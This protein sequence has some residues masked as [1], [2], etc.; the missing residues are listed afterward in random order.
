MRMMRMMNMDFGVL[1]ETKLTNGI[2]TKKAEGYEI[3][4]TNAVS[5]H[6][7][8]V[9]LFYRRS[10]QWHIE[11]TKTFGPNVI[12]T[13]LVSG[14][15]RWIIIGAYVPP[16]ETDGA[17]LDLIQQA[18]TLT[19]VHPLIMLGDFNVEL[20]P[21]RGQTYNQRHEETSALFASLGLQD[22][23][24]NFVQRR[25]WKDW[26]WSQHRNQDRIRSVC[27]YI[28]VENRK[29]FQSFQIKQPRFDSDHRLLKAQLMLQSIQNHRRYVQKREVFPLVISPEQQNKA[30][31]L[32]AE[33]T[34]A[35]ARPKKQD[36]NRVGSWISEKSWRL[37]D[38]RLEAK[39]HWHTERATELGKELRKSL[40]KDRQSR[41]DQAALSIETYLQ[42]RDNR[43]AYGVL[44]GWYKQSTGHVPKPT[45]RDEK[46]T[47][48]EFET[49]FT[50]REPPGDPI[51]IHIDPRPTINDDPPSEEEI[52][53]AI[54]GMGLNKAPGASGIRVEHLRQW[55]KGATQ[56]KNPTFVEEWEKILRLVEMAFTGEN[57]P[58]AFC[59]GILVLIPKDVPDEYRGI[60]L[61]EVLYKL[62]SSIINRRMANKIP[63]HDSIHGFR[64]KR[65]TGTAIIEAKLHMQLTQRAKKPLFMIFL[66]LKKAYDTLNRQRTMQILEGYGVGVNIRRFIETIW[67]GDTMIP[68]QAG[69][70]G[71]PFRARRGVRQGDIMSPIIFNIVADAVIREWE[72]LVEE[73]EN[74]DSIIGSLFYADDGVLSGNDA[75]DIQKAMNILT[76]VFSRVGLQMN[77]TKTKAMV[78]TGGKVNAPISDRAY[79]RKITGIGNTSREIRLQKIECKLCGARISNAGLSKHQSS[80]KCQLAAKSY[81]THLADDLARPTPPQEQPTMRNY[82]PRE[83]SFS[84]VKGCMTGCPLEGCPATFKTPDLM[85]KH[86]RRRHPLDTVIIEEEGPLPKCPQCGLFQRYVGTLHQN[87]K[88]C[89]QFAIIQANRI[90]GEEQKT[91]KQTIFTI[92]S[93]P[94]ETVQEFKYLGR[95]LDDRDQDLPAVT[96]N[97]QRAR[98]RWGMIGRILKK[99]GANPKAMASFYKAI[100]QSIL[101]YGSESWVLTK[102]ML[103][104]LNNFHHRCARFITGRHIRVD[105]N[106]YWTYPS[107]GVTLSQAG[108]FTME[109]Y[110][111]RRKSTIMRYVKDRPIYTQCTASSP[112]AYN[113]RQLVWWG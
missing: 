83:F 58:A 17:T 111:K 84:L 104:S 10:K 14:S 66:D 38:E 64:A 101:L 87:T 39:R 21:M 65:G 41:I 76:N 105:V 2:H 56:P 48:L 95:I 62:I 63:F 31:Q 59:N 40:R 53:M 19:N 92:G 35:V 15:K 22:L 97:L 5:K 107:T 110:I 23:G 24:R 67:E 4:A 91:A 89:Q 61:L 7:G 34:A 96:Y 52:M 80:R 108:L 78:M 47:R 79:S 81:A 11:G 37:M 68:K 69:F 12:R 113:P 72:V 20:Q 93:T 75:L 16:S 1:T 103:D 55:M 25:G 73:D 29:D 57:I 26:T 82:V 28:L 33:L 99:K 44:Q 13:E 30:D 9:A 42:A 3:I 46:R 90:L 60:A 86:F 51:R 54:R 45:F 50:E 88:E 27:D 109:E 98:K 49:L 6:Q 18:A 36:N 102:S 32:L 8:G 43:R 85:R 100:V 106:G 74:I 71:K 94:I 77:A 70:F 112:I